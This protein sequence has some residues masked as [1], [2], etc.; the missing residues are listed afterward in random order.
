VTVTPSPGFVG[1]ARITLTAHD[2]PNGP[3]DWRGRT[4]EQ[5]FDLSVGL[6]TVTGSKWEDLDRDGT[7]DIGDPGLEGVTIFLDLN[8]NGLLDNPASVQGE[9][10][11]VTDV[12][13]E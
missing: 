12:N 11:A 9:P 13:G 10:I 4:A 5:A 7:R 2:G 1:T 3:D 8:G 6:G